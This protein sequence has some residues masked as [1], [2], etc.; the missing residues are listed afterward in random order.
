MI[1][2][3]DARRAQVYIESMIVEVD[4]DKAAEF[5]IQWQGLLGKNG[6]SIGVVG[7]HQLRHR[8]QH[9]LAVGRPRK[10]P[11]SGAAAADAGAGG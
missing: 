10:A 1:D 6:D 4:A 9:H 11:A 3:L 2:Q 8:R 5:G 7:G